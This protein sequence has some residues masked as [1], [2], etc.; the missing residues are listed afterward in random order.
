MKTKMNYA[1]LGISMTVLL[2]LSGCADSVNHTAAA[3]KSYESSY[4]CA[5]HLIGFFGGLVAGLWAVLNWWRAQNLG[6]WLRKTFF[7]NVKVSA[8]ARKQSSPLDN[9]NRK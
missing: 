7:P 4:D 3:S 2:A 6:R 1:A 9:K 5:I 8:P